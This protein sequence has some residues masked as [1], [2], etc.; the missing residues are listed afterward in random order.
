M[1]RT[2]CISEV[3]S[4]P[5]PMMTVSACSS[6]TFS[7]AALT[8]SP[9]PLMTTEFG[10][11]VASDNIYYLPLR[12][13]AQSKEPGPEVCAIDVVTGKIVKEARSRKKPNGSIEVPGNLLFYHGDVISQT[14]LAVASYPQLKVKLAQ[15]DERLKSNANDPIGLTDARSADPPTSAAARPRGSGRTRRRAIRRGPGSSPRPRRTKITGNVPRSRCR[16]SSIVKSPHTSRML[17]SGRSGP[18]AFAV[19]LS[20]KRMRAAVALTQGVRSGQPIAALLG[21]QLERGL[22]EDHPGVELDA[23][24][25]AAR[26]AG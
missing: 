5:L 2:Q 19:N 24:I 4:M 15:I 10:Q 20:S 18:T 25:G 7:M 1:R 12:E 11:G 13:S 17:P 14:A 6:L 22:H 8:S 21:Y 3:T 23:F 26:L 16:R 9:C